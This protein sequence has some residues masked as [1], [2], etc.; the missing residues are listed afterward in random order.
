MSKKRIGMLFVVGGVVLLL[1]GLIWIKAFPLGDG[2]M[3][4][5]PYI[6]IGFGCGIF[7]HGIGDLVNERAFRNYPELKKQAE[8]E[9]KDERNMTVSNRA[10]GKAFDFM[11]YLFAGLML[12]F[13][14]MGVGF[15]V[16]LPLVVVYLIVVGVFIFYFGKYQ[17]EM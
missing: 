12:A 9:A 15:V 17:K 10:K 1:C 13:V 16:V 3:L 14:L 4:V 6:F 5:L 7:G 2:L 8:I 11:I